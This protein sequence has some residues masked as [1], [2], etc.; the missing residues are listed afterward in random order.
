[1]H[2]NASFLPPFVERAISEAMA[3]GGGLAFLHSHG[4]PGWQDMSDGDVAAEQSLAAQARAATGRPLVGLTLGTDGAWSARFERTISSWGLAA[5]ADL[6]RLRVGVIGAGSVGSMVAE[7]LART[8]IQRI[9]LLDFDGIEERNL[10]RLLHATAADIGRA[11]V[12]VLAAGI[13]RGATANAF[14]A[15][16]QEWS[17]VEEEGFRLAL[18]CDVLFSCVDRPW[19]RSAMNLIAYAHLIPVIDGGIQVGVTARRTL[20]RADW[21]AHVAAP[22]RRCLECLGQYDPGAVAAERD[23]FFDDPKYIEGLPADHAIR[24]NENVFGFSMSAASFEVLQ[25]LTMVIAPMG[26]ASPGAQHYHFVPGGLD[27]PDVRGC[28]EN[29]LYP[30]LVAR[31]DTTGIEVTAKHAVAEQ[32]RQ[33]RM[34]HRQVKLNIRARFLRFIHRIYRMWSLAHE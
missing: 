3:A 31:G 1:M 11:K 24:A 28:E 5:Q 25:F 29:C 20:K 33:S 15:D 17:V 21:R 26:V 8:G 32:R 27:E 9:R 12:T 7:P 6:A 4:G 22:S 2:G 30:S 34:A 23:G 19:P 10:D 16:A 13:T 18:D 14:T